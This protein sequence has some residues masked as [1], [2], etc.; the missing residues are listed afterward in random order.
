MR[1]PGR[2]KAVLLL[3]CLALPATGV[4]QEASGA[5]EAADPWEP[6]RLLEGS[7]SGAIDG[8]LGQGAGKRCYEFLFNGLYLVARHT[9]VRLPQE[10]SPEGDHHRELAVY[11]YDRDRKTVV[12]REFINEG[13]ILRYACETSPRRLVCTTEDV[14]NGRGMKARL[15]IEIADRF[16]F[17]EVFELASPGQDLQVYFTN[18][19]T[20][21]PDLED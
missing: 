2:M 17:R 18:E 10:K 9:S 13:Y 1:R 20:R 11:S 5:A 4:T 12:L 3:C 19:W 16:R 7:W 15:T 14:E 21:I 6:L 8:R